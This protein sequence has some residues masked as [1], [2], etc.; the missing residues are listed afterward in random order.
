MKIV[1]KILIALLLLV[2]V[3]VT[4]GYLHF[5]RDQ[6]I[7]VGFIPSEFSYCGRTIT[8][9]DSKYKEITDWLRTNS[10]GWQQ[11]WNTQISGLKY[12]YPSFSVV[13]FKGGVSVSYKTD[14][15]FPRFIKSVDHRLNT[16][17]TKNS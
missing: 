3:M 11:D 10:D 8:H 14:Y 6:K 9:N 4:F 12:Y 2:I 5:V 13:V 1:A 16:E 7:E 17:C 15:G